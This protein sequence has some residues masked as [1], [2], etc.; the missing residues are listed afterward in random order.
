MGTRELRERGGVPLDLVLV[1]VVVAV[2]VG[3]LG[4]FLVRTGG[5]F[6][7][8]VA[9]VVGL[10]TAVVMRPVFRR[11][12]ADL[13]DRRRVVGHDDSWTSGREDE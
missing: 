11:R 13:Q 7:L 4:W 12:R 3:A 5:W 2:V 9:V 1:A 8:L 6:W 10:T